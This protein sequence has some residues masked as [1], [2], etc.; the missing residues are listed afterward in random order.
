VA[1]RT[2]S[3]LRA[4]LLSCAALQRCGVLRS[5]P[6]ARVAQA[7]TRRARDG[8]WN[9]RTPSFSPTT[10]PPNNTSLPADFRSLPA[11]KMPYS[12]SSDSVASTVP[13]GAADA[14]FDDDEVT[15]VLQDGILH[16]MARLPGS[17]RAATSCAT[18]SRARARAG[19]DGPARAA[20]AG[21]ESSGA[22]WPGARL[23]TVSRVPWPSPVTPCA[24]LLPR[25]GLRAAQQQCAAHVSK[26]VGRGL[27][28]GTVKTWSGKATSTRRTRHAG[29]AAPRAA[30]KM[31][32]R[33]TARQRRAP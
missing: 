10:V 31:R 20:R 11:P 2:H 5:T 13:Y 24:C 32:R 19:R 18:R 26:L 3:A 33:C 9:A 22:G 25:V 21:A 4:P 14:G 8:W 16:D 15:S 1:R 17:R 29:S 7:A 6:P 27:A 28:T 30:R 23:S 12:S